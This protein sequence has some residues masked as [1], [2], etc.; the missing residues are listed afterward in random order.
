MGA[1]T[2]REQPSIR[3]SIRILFG[4]SRGYLLVNAANLGDGIAYFGIL[5][6]LTLFMQHDVGFSASWATRSVGWFTGAVTIFM[7]LGGGVVSDRLGVRR[8]LSYCI[9][10]L[11]VGRVL[12]VVSPEL[13]GSAAV[14]TGAGLSLLLMAVGEGVIQPALYSGIK[15]YTDRRTE[16]LG[17]AFLYSIMNVGIAIGGF[18]SPLIRE[19]WAARVE[20][21]R[22]LDDPTAGIAGAFWVFVAV[23]VL[24]LLVNLTG[25][26]RE[27]ERR[28]RNVIGGAS[29]LGPFRWREYL[30][31]LPIL[32]RRFLFFIL[33]LLPVRTLFAHQ[34]LTMPDYVTRTMPSEVGARW[35][36]INIINPVVIVIFVPL[37]A[38]LTLRRRVVDMMIVGTTISALCSFL[39]VPE[40]ELTLL[41]LYML[42]WS[43]G[44]AVWSSRFLEYVADIAPVHRV[45]IYMGIAGIPWFLAKTTTGIYAG[46]V[47][48]AFVPVG[49]PQRAGT[50]WLIY[51][52][53]ALVT[54][55]SLIAARR[56]LERGASAAEP[57]GGSGGRD[58]A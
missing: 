11:V 38:A 54:P 29:E 39:L 10:T 45:G 9:A 22:V 33:A 32:D 21:R 42:L 41:L 37:I 24:M 57:E 58:A 44:E 40:P 16:T 12:L 6:L 52:L 43:L 20:G 56:W 31:K 50:M 23:T 48:D 18:L 13:G 36:W 4:A 15:E 8:A 30:R 25:F 1:G 2:D 53:I 26:T 35:E 7:A 27:V 14:A 46:D 3:E 47:L 34:Y 28:D 49:G 55:V 51:G 5:T 17:Y 19:A